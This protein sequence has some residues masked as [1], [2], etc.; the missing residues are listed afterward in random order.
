MKKSLKPFVSVMLVVFFM[1]NFKPEAKAWR[2]FGWDSSSST[3]TAADGQCW[4]HTDSDY[5]FRGINFGGSQE[6]DG[7]EKC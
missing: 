4:T 3:H 6:G 1:L 7:W 2:L 5:Y